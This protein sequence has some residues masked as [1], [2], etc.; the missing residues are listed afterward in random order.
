M[1]Q[2]VCAAC[3]DIRIASE[4][5]GRIEQRVRVASLPDTDEHI[6]TKRREPLQIEAGLPKIKFCLEKRWRSGGLVQWQQHIPPERRARDLS[7]RRP[8][9]RQQRPPEQ[10][11]HRFHAELPPQDCK[12]LSALRIEA[13]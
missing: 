12:R 5:P 1:Q 9:K 6:V 11:F 8:V 10:R 3:D 7:Q 2:R 13:H 4:I